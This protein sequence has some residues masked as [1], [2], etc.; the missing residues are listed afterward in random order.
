M[1][2][3]IC[4]YSDDDRQVLDQMVFE[5]QDYFSK[6]DNAGE[7]RSF[8]SVE[9][10]HSYMNTIF[11]DVRKMSGKVFM[12]IENGEIIGFIQGVIIDKNDCQHKKRK[13]GWVGLLFVKEEYRNKKV[14]RE[15]FNELRE[16]FKKSGCNTMRLLTLVDNKN[17]IDFYK[18]LGLEMREVE[19]LITI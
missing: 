2:T 6:V 15:L 11:D 18:R 10:A 1:K 16:Y 8:D 13:D 12:A 14:G 5:L 17:A 4:E 9:E 7:N 3:V 19:M